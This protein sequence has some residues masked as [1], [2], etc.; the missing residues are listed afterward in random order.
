MATILDV[1]RRAGVS[2]TTVSRVMNGKGRIS[3]ATR[4]AV[5]KAIADLDYR[6]NVLAQSLSNQTTNSIGLII[7]SGYHRSQYIMGL[8][9]LAHTMATQANKFLIVTQTDAN[10]TDSG[11]R[12][13]KELVDRRCDGILYYKTSHIEKDDNDIK[14][15]QLIDELP[16]PLVVLNHQLPTKPDNYVW[17]DQVNSGRLAIDKLIAL[18]HRK[19]AYLCGPLHIN[20]ARQRFMGYQQALKAH[21]IPFDP[22]LVVEAAPFLEGGHHACEQLL[23]RQ[24][25]F[26]AI[27]CYNDA[28]AV[29]TL[30]ALTNKGISV[31][32]DVS[33]FGFDNEDISSYTQPAISSVELP[34]H[35]MVQHACDMLFYQIE[36]KAPPETP[37]TDLQAKIV[38]RESVKILK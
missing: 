20:T 31:P 1:S 37:F 3:Q 4:D 11:I 28:I 32:D 18:G 35:N 6:P 9:D 17:F 2:K 15:A 13:I 33:L 30:K 7:P 38:L 12:T 5:F 26:T 22:L 14:L 27:A 36:H 23:Q 25:P 19:I 24:V 8:M 29:G 10:N 21:G 34:V 16:I